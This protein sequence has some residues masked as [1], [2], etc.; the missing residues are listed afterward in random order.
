MTTQSRKTIL[1]ATDLQSSVLNVLDANRLYPTAYTPYGHCPL[2]GLLSLLGFTG[3][4]IDPLTGH[5]HLGNGYRQFNPVLMRFNAPDD[6]SPFG[7]GGLN[8]YAYCLGDPINKSDPNGR[9]PIPNLFGAAAKMLIGGTAVGGGIGLI[10]YAQ[11]KDTTVNFLLTSLGALVVTIG[12]APLSSLARQAVKYGRERLK[13]PPP[14]SYRAALDM[15]SLPVNVPSRPSS[16]VGVDAP[17]NNSSSA[18][19]GLPNYE[20]ATRWLNPL[21]PNYTQATLNAVAIKLEPLQIR[22]PQRTPPRGSI[23]T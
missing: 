20:E 14:P 15:P 11:S 17:S 16:T 1:P 2:D 3:E 18:N 13:N 10:M 23:R 22:D 6:R 8:T 4:L 21:D 19:G 12:L 9:I 5:Y 7:K